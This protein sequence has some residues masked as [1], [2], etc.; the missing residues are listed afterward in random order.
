M[1]IYR[2][3]GSPFWWYDIAIIGGRLRGSTKVTSRSDA[4]LVEADIRRK[5]VVAG[6]TGDKPT[7]T[8]DQACGRYWLDHA[9]RLP[10]D[11]DV[12]NCWVVETKVTPC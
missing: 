9:H 2:R 10:I 12:L 11:V 5:A 1:S 4:L 8:L 6:I 3:K 7:M